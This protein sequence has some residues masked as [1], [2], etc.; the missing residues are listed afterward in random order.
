MTNPKNCPNGVS[1]SVFYK[2][3]LDV[4]PGDLGTDLHKYKDKRETLLSTGGD[5]GYPGLQIYREGPVF[6][7]IVSTGEETWE[8][9]VMGNLPKN[10]SWTN[11]ALRWEPLKFTDADSYEKAKLEYKTSEL[12]GLQLLLNLKMIGHSLLR[13][14]PACACDLLSGIKLA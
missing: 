13:T 11:V 10:N 8:V 12:G 5:Y 4:D 1:V 2:A 6:G 9:K 14:G 7:A 3:E